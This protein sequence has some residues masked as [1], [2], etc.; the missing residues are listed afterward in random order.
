MIRIFT[1]E[2][3][4]NEGKADSTEAHTPD[5]GDTHAQPEPGTRSNCVACVSRSE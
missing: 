4:T 5:G 3:K 1:T 2:R